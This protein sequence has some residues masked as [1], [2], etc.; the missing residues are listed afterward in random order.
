MSESDKTRVRRWWRRVPRA[1]LA[2]SLVWAVSPMYADPL[3]LSPDQRA[4]R[5]EIGA[6][7]PEARLLWTRDAR[8][9][10]TRLGSWDPEPVTPDDVNSAR[11]RWSPD[12]KRIVYERGEAVWIMNADFTNRRLVLRTAHTADWTGTGRAIT[13]IAHGGYQVVR[14]DL[15]SGET[16]VIYDARQSPWS[17]HPVSQG[18]ELHPNGRYLLTFKEEPDH[19]VLIVDLE[20]GRY[21]AN[22]QM[23]RGD[24]KPAWSPDGT[25]LLTTARTTDRPVL[26]TPFEFDDGTV[27]QSEFLI[28]L[29]SLLRYYAH[30]GR[31]SND[32]E[33]V[34]FG[35]KVLI[36][37]SMWGGREIYIWK[38][39]SPQSERVR[40]TF[41]GD[42]D[43]EPSLYI[44]KG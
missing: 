21:I 1:A 41:D 35:G 39:G 32:G 23:G 34:V 26:I 44:P 12:G 31:L 38:R 29:D 19:S 40:L 33:W 9:Y 22:E 20:A 14:H 5:Q 11:P 30:D 7:I 4:A 13:V 24:C 25:A 43:G 15:D 42:E 18:A 36:G 37:A 28:G 3:E 8:I 2:W 16:E 27:G 17:G 10:H 6:R